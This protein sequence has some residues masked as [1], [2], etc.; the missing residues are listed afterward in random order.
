M[1]KATLPMLLPLLA[2]LCAVLVAVIDDRR[3]RAER[4]RN[5]ETMASDL[6]TA[7]LHQRISER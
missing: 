6:S 3:N 7:P 4:T 1:F 5:Q 2:Y